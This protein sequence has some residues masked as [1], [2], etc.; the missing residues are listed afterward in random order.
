MQLPEIATLTELRETQDFSVIADLAP[1]RRI[2][3]RV[4]T[5]RYLLYDYAHDERSRTE[6]ARATG[7]APSHPAR[8]ARGLHRARLRQD[9]DRA[10]RSPGVAVGRRD[11][12]LLPLEGGPVRVAPR[13][14]PRRVRR[15]ADAGPGPHRRA[16]PASR[17]V[18]RAQR[19]GRHRRR[20]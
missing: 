9:V 20:G 16:E 17:G 3:N 13:G 1:T 12:S 2:K 7:P 10:D 11:L 15:R 5:S 4:D 14:H 19:V 6:A 8:R 18:G